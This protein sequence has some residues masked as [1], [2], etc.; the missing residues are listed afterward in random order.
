L[1][2]EYAKTKKVD[3]EFNNQRVP[4]TE[5]AITV[6]RQGMTTLI[7]IFFTSNDKVSNYEK[8]NYQ[9]VVIK[10]SFLQSQ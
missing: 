8:L 10:T 2:D 5:M 4:L 1:E 7:I 6:L 3:L 9:L